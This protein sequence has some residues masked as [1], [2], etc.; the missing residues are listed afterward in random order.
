MRLSPYINIDWE[1]AKK[2]FDQPIKSSTENKSFP[3]TKEILRILAAVGTIGLTFAFPKVGTSIGRLL[4][5]DTS[6]SNW[7]TDQMLRQLRRQKYI[8]I[9][10]NDNGSTTV[11]ITQNGLVRALTY[12]IEEM[13]IDKSKEWDK[14]W[15]VVIFDIPNKHK[16]IRDIFRMRLHQLGLHQ[17]QES[18]YIHPYP[19][20]KQIEFLREIYGVPFTVNYLLVEKLEDD[21]YLRE[22]FELN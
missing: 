6:Y 11:K 9:K 14:K 2:L 17:L 10:T 4:L 7:S 12:Q 1:K 8:E 20:F 3:S 13:T 22:R 18:T 15:R 21:E 16:R 5:G 19:C